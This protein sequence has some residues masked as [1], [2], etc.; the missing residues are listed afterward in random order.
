[1]NKTKEKIT[2]R[3][4]VGCDSLIDSDGKYI[5]LSEA[6]KIIEQLLGEQKKKERKRILIITK[7]AL[8]EEYEGLYKAIEQ[9]SD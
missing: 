1:M 4:L 3:L 2:K 9:Y 7:A 6:V 5:K 8:G